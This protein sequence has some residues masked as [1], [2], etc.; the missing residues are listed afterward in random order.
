MK[1]ERAADLRARYGLKTP[2]ALQIG[3]ALESGCDAF[4]C[5]D[6]ALKRVTELR[7]LALDEL[8]L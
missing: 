6:L 2:D 8:E 4:L 5:N 1:A 7:V 3:C